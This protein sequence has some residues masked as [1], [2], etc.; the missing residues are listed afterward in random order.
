MIRGGG[1]EVLG[2]DSLCVSLSLS[3]FSLSLRT[4]VCQYASDMITKYNHRRTRESAGLSVNRMLLCVTSRAPST[5]APLLLFLLYPC[6]RPLPAHLTAYILYQTHPSVRPLKHI[7]SPL[8]K[9]VSTTVMCV[10]VFTCQTHT[11]TETHR[12]ARKPV[13]NAWTV[14]TNKSVSSVLHICVT[15]VFVAVICMHPRLHL[16]VFFA[17]ESTSCASGYKE[18]RTIV[19]RLLRSGYA[20]YG[21]VWKNEKI[22]TK[23]LLVRLSDNYDI[24]HL[25]TPN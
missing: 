9:S 6:R 12:H 20:Y 23:L 21:Y 13:E 16:F 25:A 24:N 8:V 11:Y 17:R 10:C 2:D 14:P 22:N 7:A 19:S 5:S 18:N 4:T 3:L 15:C 1:E